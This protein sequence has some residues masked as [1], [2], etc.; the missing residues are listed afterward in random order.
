[1]EKKAFRN[2]ERIKT[3]QSTQNSTFRKYASRVK[4]KERHFQINED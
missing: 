3:K 1:M 4:I 2:T